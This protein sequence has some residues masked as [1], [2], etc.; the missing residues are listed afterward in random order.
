MMRTLSAIIF[1]GLAISACA[2]SPLYVGER[3]PRGTVG[4]VPRDGQGEPIWAA[5][6]GAPPT[7]P[8]RPMP[9]DQ[10]IPVTGPGTAPV[11]VTSAAPAVSYAPLPPQTEK[12]RRKGCQHLRSCR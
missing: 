2:P 10:G 5:I 9:T 12:A 6:P 3:R 7:Q 8:V 4:E 11:A 1:L